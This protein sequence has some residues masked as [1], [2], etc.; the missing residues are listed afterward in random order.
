MKLQSKRNTKLIVAVVIIA[1]IIAIALA[2]VIITSINNANNDEVVIKK[3]VVSIPPRIDYYVGEKFDAA[4]LRIQVLMTDGTFYFV[5][6]PNSELKITGFDSSV[7]NDSVLLKI[8]Y[9]GFETDF[10]VRIQERP[11]AAPV[12]KS[13]ALSDNFQTTYTMKDWNRKGPNRDNVAIILIYS[14]GSE[15]RVPFLTEN[16]LDLD[17]NITSPCTTQ[18]KVRYNDGGVIVET[19]VTVTITN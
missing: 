10:T 12:L 5:D 19:T 7:V 9:K 6:Y 4:N 16:I 2:A 1:I 18:F 14:D 17:R 13:V 8:A 11:S 15:K 3:I